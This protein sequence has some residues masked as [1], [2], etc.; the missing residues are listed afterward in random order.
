MPTYNYKCSNGHFHTENRSIHADEPVI[1]CEECSEEMKRT[2][3]VPVINL[4]GRGYYS[5]GG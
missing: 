2:Y 3:Q 5:K 1:T 4:M